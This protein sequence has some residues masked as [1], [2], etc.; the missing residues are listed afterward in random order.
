MEDEN[1]KYREDIIDD[2]N[3]NQFPEALKSISPFIDKDKKQ[4]KKVTIN[5]SKQENQSD[6]QIDNESPF[7]SL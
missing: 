6:N 1:L 4:K 5:L 2:L 3:N 7:L